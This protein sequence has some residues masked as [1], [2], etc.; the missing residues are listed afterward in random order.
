MNELKLMSIE[1]D[2]ETLAEKARQE[3][4]LEIPGVKISD[5]TVREYPLGEAAAHL[6]GYVQ[7]VTAEDLEE[8]DGEGYTS[9]SVIG[10]SGMEGLFEKELKG[11]NGCS[12]T[13]VDSNGN[14]KKIIVNTIVEN[15]KDIKLTIDSNLQKELY[16]QFKDD[17]SCSVAMNQYTGEVLALVSTPSYDNNDFIMGM[18]NE[19][20]TALNE[21]ERKPMYNRFRQVWCPGSTFKPTYGLSYISYARI[22]EWKYTD[23]GWFC[24]ELCVPEPP[25][26]TEIVDG[27]CLVR[28]KPLSKEQREM[29]E[30][31]VQGLGYQ[32]NNLLCSNWDTD[33]MEKLDYNG[34]YEYLYAMKHQKAFDA[35]DYPNG[36]PKEE[37]ES[38]IM[39]YLP[40]TAEQIQEYA[41]FDEKNQT[42]VWVRLGCLNY[43]PTFFGTSLP[44][45]IDIKEN[46]DGTVTLTVDAVCDMVICDDAVI[47]HELTVK[48][49]DDGSF[50]YLGNKILDDGIKE[51]PAYQYR[52]K[53]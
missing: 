2:Q 31:C 3:K 40:V 34:I 17:K 4:L 22:K 11:Q 45:V 28:I 44:E 46:E 13:I 1:P 52:I 12:I 36:I 19:K 35:E 14:K 21:D 32:G 5:I 15:G 16:E 8:H 38:L 33:H 30:R 18:S 39:E 29:S 41:V 51:I 50:Q 42:Y 53:E 6:V 26:V 9:N 47:T 25:E 20:W 27:S 43:A 23:K 10:K 7:N 48:F 37:F 49:A 24:Y